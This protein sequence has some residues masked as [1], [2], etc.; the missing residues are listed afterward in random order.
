MLPLC[1]MFMEF[2]QDPATVSTSTPPPDQWPA[3]AVRVERR[4]EQ[5]DYHFDNPSNFEPGP[6]VPHFFEQ[7]YESGNTWLFVQADYSIANTALT[8]EVGFTPRVTTFA[9]DIDTVFQPS[10]DVI[11]S[12]TRGDV[13]LRS[14]SIQQHIALLRWRRWR[15]G[16]VVGYRRS[17]VDY[18]PSDRIVTHSRPPSEIPSRCS[19]TRTRGRTWWSQACRRAQ[20]CTL[21]HVGGLRSTSRRS[22]SRGH[23]SM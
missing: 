15:L 19:A 10:G 5:F 21:G 7:H 1:L 20:L 17:A 18:L 16:V 6:L 13:R 22:R 23:A 12:G 8:T 11:T 2:L 3:V 14:V 9:S 4:T